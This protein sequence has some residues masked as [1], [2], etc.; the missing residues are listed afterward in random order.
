MKIK[1]VSPSSKDEEIINRMKIKLNMILGNIQVND[2]AKILEKTVSELQQLNISTPVECE[3]EVKTVD[4]KSVL[5]E[6]CSIS[7]I[8][9]KV[10][11]FS[12][13]EEKGEV[14]CI[15]CKSTFKFDSS[16][17]DTGARK[18]SRQIILLKDHLK[19]H[20]DT[21]THKTALQKFNAK[22]NIEHKEC[23]RNTQVGEN[24]ARTS[25]Y[26]LKKGRPG[27]FTELLSMQ[28]KN[29]VD[30]GDLNHSENFVR[31]IAGSFSNVIMKRVKHHLSNRLVQTG[32]LPPCKVIEDGATSRHDTRL[33]IGLT[34][35]FPGDKPL[36]QSVFLAASRGCER[37]RPLSCQKFKDC[38]VR[39][40]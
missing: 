4:I 11:E 24:I 28:Q 9:R 34:T 15:V 1:V 37:R 38:C 2:T 10:P 20:L 33:I 19:Y 13:N 23:L 21:A 22:E 29:K 31:K 7:E 14:L 40:Y 16:K 27:D 36:F 39:L 5:R 18:L 32:C 35:V 17:E 6:C 25:Y 26:L 12:H 30:I 8:E 3:E